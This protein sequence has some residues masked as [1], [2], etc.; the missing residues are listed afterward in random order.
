MRHHQSKWVFLTGSLF[1]SLVGCASDSLTSSSAPPPPSHVAQAPGETV[2][3]PSGAVHEPGNQP[4]TGTELHAPPISTGELAQTPEGAPLSGEVQ[5][6]AV[7]RPG[8]SGIAGNIPPPRYVGPTDNLTKVANAIQ[9]RHK[10]LTTL[11]VV[12]PGL[13]LTQPVTISIALGGHCPTR[14]TQTYVAS[15]GNHF[16]YND[17]EGD[18]KPRNG[19]VN[20]TLTEPNP[21]GGVYDF[22]LPWNVMLDPLYDV[23]YSWF[24]FTLLNTCNLVG[25]TEI[26]FYGTSPD[27]QR[28]KSTLHTI[29]G[30]E[31]TITQFGWTRT[32]V[33]ASAN[34]NVQDFWFTTVNLIDPNDFGLGFGRDW[35][36]SPTS[37]PAR[38]RHSK[39]A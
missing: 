29:G 1:L 21:Q 6:R 4:A 34:L 22:P 12:A 10:S 36:R 26:D 20:I 24:Q 23:T 5:E 14:V 31:N 28:H 13:A 37:C 38:P 16:L 11:V 35:V 25:D 9:V 2:Q 17:C 3:P 19:L 8:P 33:S 7:P 18:G 15:S 39:A 30:R 32:E 27:K